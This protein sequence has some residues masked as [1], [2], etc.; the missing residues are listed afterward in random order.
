M[1]KKRADKRRQEKEVLKEQKEKEERKKL[2]LQELEA[3]RKEKP[4]GK[5]HSVATHFVQMNGSHGSD[6]PKSS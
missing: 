1:A 3:K 5:R 2:N 6:G 4:G